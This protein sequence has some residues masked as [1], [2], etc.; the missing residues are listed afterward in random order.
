ML[1]ANTIKSLITDKKVSLLSTVYSG[2]KDADYSK[3]ATVE[4]L[5]WDQKEA[6]AKDDGQW[7]VRAST[8]L[9]N[10]GTGVDLGFY[11]ANYHSKVPYIQMMGKSGVL[12]GDI[13]GAYTHVFYDYAGIAAAGGGSVGVFDMTGNTGDGAAA[14]A[15]RRQW[16]AQEETRLRSERQAHLLS[17]GQGQHALRRG[18]FLL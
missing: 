7:G 3:A 9:D 14:A 5:Q 15:R 10:V 13:I 17:L 12:A 1:K 18:Q 6:A 4:L 2:T 16:A 11:Y 8:Y